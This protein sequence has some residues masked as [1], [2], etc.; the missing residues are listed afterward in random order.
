M[1]YGHTFNC[2]CELSHQWRE[3]FFESSQKLELEEFTGKWVQ[4]ENE[5]IGVFGWLK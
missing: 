2:Y 5:E 3:L 4:R 1:D